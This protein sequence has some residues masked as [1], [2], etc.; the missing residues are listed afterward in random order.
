[1]ECLDLTE[2]R[3][4]VEKLFENVDEGFVELRP[5]SGSDVRTEIFSLDEI[6]NLMDNVEQYAGDY[7]VFLGIN[8]RSNDNG[9]GKD[10]DVEQVVTMWSDIDAKDF[11]GGKEEAYEAISNFELEPTYI[12]DSG[13]GWHVYWLLQEPWQLNNDNQR[14]EAKK[15]SAAIHRI[16]DADSTFNLSRILRM[17]G[18]PNIKEDDNWKPC[19]IQSM[20]SGHKYTINEFYEAI[21]DEYLEEDD[22]SSSVDLD[23]DSDSRISS[24]EDLSK[25]V[26]TRILQRAE[27]IPNRL[28]GD[29]SQ[30]DFWVA[31][32]L[33]ETGLND[34]E[35]LQAF[36]IFANHDW[37]A[38]QKLKQRGENYLLEYT[39]PKAKNKV[40]SIDAKLEEIKNANNKARASKGIY[41]LIAQKDIIEKEEALRRLQD[42]WGGSGSM[43]L[44]TLR[45]K[46]SQA[47]RA[48]GVNDDVQQFFTFDSQGGRNFKPPRLGKHILSNRPYMK[49]ASKM[50]Y[51]EDGVFK[52]GGRDKLDSE[53]SDYLGDDW[54]K[55]YASEAVKWVE[56]N[57]FQDSEIVDSHKGLINVKN[58][59]LDIEKEE[60]IDHSPEHLST[61][62]IRAK[63]DPDAECPR[64]E[65]F[66]Y[67]IFPNEVVPLVWEHAGYTLLK[68]FNLKKILI[69]V[70]EGNNGKSVFLDLILNMLGDKNVSNKSLQSLANETF[71]TAQLFGKMANIYSDLNGNAVKQTGTLKM[72]TG[73]DK[74]DAQY[75]YG[76]SFNFYNNAKL[77]FSA[78]KLPPVHDYNKA[79]FDRLHI[80]ECPYHFTEE[81]AD[82]ELTKKLTTE[83]AMSAFLNKALE[84]AQR[85]L[86]NKKFSSIPEINN[87][88][89]RY[90]VSSDSVSEF[91][92]TRTESNME[93]K[94]SKKKLYTAY[95]HW[96]DRQNRKPVAQRTFSRRG[97][98]DPN[99]L[100]SAKKEGKQV[101]RGIELLNNSQSLELVI[102]NKEQEG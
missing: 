18:T 72:L 49:T 45:K 24:L 73:G 21:P 35:V 57:T 50:F 28:E 3:M 55:H 85:L 77:I 15:L 6:N 33:Y 98:A 69:L 97:K 99:N 25:L 56:S 29:R 91:L 92:Y 70:G 5:I 7:N 40:N 60:L 82:P 94:T 10:G 26:S 66:M 59:M 87:N 22:Y 34:N 9:A 81:E 46:V 11:D 44:T 62:Q 68:G 13:N 90:R 4:F 31:T 32:E 19:S 63:Y 16:V 38:G 58:G 88:L 54:K 30:N 86:E 93:A 2:T 95:K 75:K 71:A 36:K 14:E 100:V 51:Y 52:A 47:E 74:V 53:I 102:N 42:A 12:V 79:F 48:M 96:C 39:L 8:P 43:A 20:N 78:N 65:Q 67:E 27:A 23:L 80:V 101:W 37:D 1:M 17:P 41:K 83:N 76:K 84:G 64:L 89:H 61:S